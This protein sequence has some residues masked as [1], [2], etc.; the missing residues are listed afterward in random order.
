MGTIFK[1]HWQNSEHSSC[2]HVCA[3]LPQL[4]LTHCDPVHCSPPA[5]LENPTDYTGKNTRVGCH[6]ILQGIFPIQVSNPHLLHLLHRRA[7]SLP[8][9]PP[10]KTSTCLI[11]SNIPQNFFLELI[12]TLEEA[13]AGIKIARRNINNLRYADDTTLKAEVKKN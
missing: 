10:G 6:D 12:Y 7:G 3:K 2:L 13:Q 9:A 11:E 1:W 5:P 4:C 8:L